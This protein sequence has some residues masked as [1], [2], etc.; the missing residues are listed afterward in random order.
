[1]MRMWMILDAMYLVVMPA[2]M[3][4]DAKLHLHFQVSET[5]PALSPVVMSQYEI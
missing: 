3:I 5:C 4:L 2:R 1:M